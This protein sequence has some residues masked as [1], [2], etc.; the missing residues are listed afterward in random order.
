MGKHNPP[1]APSGTQMVIF[2]CLI[3]GLS[4]GEAKALIEKHGIDRASLVR[5]AQELRGQQ[6][7]ANV[8]DIDRKLR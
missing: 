5:A 8:A 6:Q 7:G 1:P 4:E 2:L 3:A